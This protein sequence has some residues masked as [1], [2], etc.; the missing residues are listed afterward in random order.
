MPDRVPQQI[1]DSADKLLRF[2]GLCYKRVTAGSE[3][4]GSFSVSSECTYNNDR[5]GL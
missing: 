2:Y 1:F 3:A 5:D 4:T